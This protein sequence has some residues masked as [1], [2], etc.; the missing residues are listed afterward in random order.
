MRCSRETFFQGDVFPGRRL[1]R[2]FC[3]SRETFFPRRF[4]FPGIFCSSDILFQGDFVPTRLFR[5][6]FCLARICFF[7]VVFNEFH[8]FL[9]TFNDFHVDSCKNRCDEVDYSETVMAT[10]MDGD[11]R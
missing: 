4:F 6:G 1:S 11:G 9:K 2:Q 8:Y 7:I 5:P 3:F 10:V